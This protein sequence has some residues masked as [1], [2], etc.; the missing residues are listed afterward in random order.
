MF[1]AKLAASPLGMSEK[2]SFINFQLYPNPATY[3]FS[4][5]SRNGKNTTLKIFNLTGQQVYQAAFQTETKV[6][7]AGFPA[8]MYL[9]KITSEGKT[10]TQKLTVTH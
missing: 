5:S 7:V 1:I 4:V 9:V 3:E 2:T 10:E 8:G 6:N